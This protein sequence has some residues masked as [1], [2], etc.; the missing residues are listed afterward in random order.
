MEEPVDTS[1]LI[2]EVAP[3]LKTDK[4]RMEDIIGR[5]RAYAERSQTTA[6]GICGDAA[7]FIEEVCKSTADGKILAAKDSEI[8]TYWIRKSIPK[9]VLES[10]GEREVFMRSVADDAAREIAVHVMSSD[11]CV[12]EQKYDEP[13]SSFIYEW[14]MRFVRNPDPNLKP[15]EGSRF[16]VSL[17]NGAIVMGQLIGVNHLSTAGASGHLGQTPQIMGSNP[18]PEQLANYHN[19]IQMQGTQYQAQAYKNPYQGLPQLSPLKS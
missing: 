10:S 9:H 8:E 15:T 3:E 7:D 19:A 1:G 5:L 6:G 16:P 18:T 4:E 11:A 2:E 12:M 14:K 13:T 17:G